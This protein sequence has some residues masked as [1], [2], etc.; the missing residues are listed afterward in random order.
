MSGEGSDRNGIGYTE[1]IEDMVYDFTAAG[2][3]QGTPTIVVV[4]A[5][6]MTI[7]PWSSKVDAQIANFYAGE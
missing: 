1:E 4:S 6:G 2:K 5:P 3:K 7:L